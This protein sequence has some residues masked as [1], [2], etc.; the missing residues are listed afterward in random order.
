MFDATVDIMHVFPKP[1]Q[2]RRMPIGLERQIID[3]GIQ[4]FHILTDQPQ[5]LQH[6]IIY[7]RRHAQPPI[8]QRA[9]K[10]PRTSNLARNATSTTQASDRGRKTFQPMR[11]NW[12]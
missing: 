3:L 5:L 8:A 1:D 4:L 6:Q 11:I 9:Q 10:E 7:I 12:S 2:D